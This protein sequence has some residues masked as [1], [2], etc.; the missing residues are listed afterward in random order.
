MQHRISRIDQSDNFFIVNK[1][2]MYNC[3]LIIMI[4]LLQ[5]QY[6]LQVLEILEIL[7]IFMLYITIFNINTI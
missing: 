7:I 6:N 2:Y 4:L 5:T 3:I 1:V